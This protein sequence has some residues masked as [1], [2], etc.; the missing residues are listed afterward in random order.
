MATT[1]VFTACQI[2]FNA[3]H[4]ILLSTSYS[5][6]PITFTSELMYWVRGLCTFISNMLSLAYKTVTAR[7]EQLA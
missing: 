1:F 6:W 4:F 3:M 2:V 5:P 7:F